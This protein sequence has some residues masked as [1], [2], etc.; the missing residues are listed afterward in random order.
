[1]N[2][3]A[4]LSPSGIDGFLNRIS[5]SESGYEINQKI[6]S[7][8]HVI[9]TDYEKIKAYLEAKLTEIILS[10]VEKK[11]NIYDFMR[12]DDSTKVNNYLI[13]F[14]KITDKMAQTTKNATPIKYKINY[15]DMT[16]K[17]LPYNLDREV[18]C[19]KDF[20]YL[21]TLAEILDTF[22]I[23]NHIDFPWTLTK[24]NIK[25]E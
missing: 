8:R 7:V 18:F 17:F 12:Y 25:E 11:G 19:G 15:E 9:E 22:Y 16:V 24:N 13:Q 14:L 2:K 23:E 10:R 21:A 4:L 20:Q 6:D 1:M 3:I 5:Y